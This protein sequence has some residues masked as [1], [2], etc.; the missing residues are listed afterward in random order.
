M[1]RRAVLFA[2]A[3][4][5]ASATA[6]A[7]KPRR[8]A[9][10]D[11]APIQLDQQVPASF[12]PWTIDKSLVPVLPDPSLQAALDQI[13]G[14]VLARTYINSSNGQRVMLSIAYGEDQGTDATAA[15][16]PEFC[17]TAQGFSV[18]SMG[19]AVLGLGG[20]NLTVRRLVGQLQSRREPITYWVTLNDRAVL[21]GFSRKL[22]QIRL[23]LMGQIPDGMLVRV[24]S[25]TAEPAAAFGLQEVFLNDL[26]A[27]LP[28]DLQSR[29]FGSRAA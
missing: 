9:S 12:G 24:S 18:A 15:H 25:L 8:R 27:A 14:Q 28:P 22:E 7:M 23:G 20:R 26:L 17:Y 11:F 5:A 6:L 10:K 4:V 19:T 21:P 16:R 13:Y 29:Y 2:G 1:K 3:A